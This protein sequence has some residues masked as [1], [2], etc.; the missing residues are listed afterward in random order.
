MSWMSLSVKTNIEW[1]VMETELV[2]LGRQFH[3][4]P[5][6]TFHAPDIIV[7]CAASDFD[8]AHSAVLEL[9]SVLSWLKRQRIEPIT[10]GKHTSSSPPMQIG[11]PPQIQNITEGFDCRYFPDLSN[12]HAR[13]ALA[14]FRDALQ[15]TNVMQAFLSYW[16]LASLLYP[17]G[18]PDQFQFLE[19]KLQAL[20]PSSDAGI[21]IAELLKTGLTYRQLVQTHLYGERRCAIAHATSG[22]VV[23]PDS[24]GDLDAVR[25]D[26]CIMYALADSIIRNEFGVESEEELYR[27]NGTPPPQKS[28]KFV[29]IQFAQNLQWESGPIRFGN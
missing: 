6:N 25:K 3:L 1:P 27:K 22:F 11:P 18:K 20:E 5:P 13:M 26:L 12:Q 15:N 19:T 14:C 4:R 10:P 16:K 7:E 8:S 9:M 23:N 29:L 17:D 21:R 28:N 24:S 2:Y